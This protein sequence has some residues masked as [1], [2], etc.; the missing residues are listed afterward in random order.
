M[1]EKLLK[2]A[3]ALCGCLMLLCLCGSKARAADY[4]ISTNDSWV[5][6]SVADREANFYTFTLPSAGMVSVTLQSYTDNTNCDLLDEDLA[7]RYT[8]TTADGSSTNPDTERF[9]CDL[10]AGTYKI[11]LKNY[12]SWKDE[13]RYRLKVSFTPAQN[14]ETEPNNTFET[15]MPL[16]NGTLIKGFLSMDDGIDFYKITIGEGANVRT[17][18]SRGD[19]S[20]YDFSI[21]NSDL[22][23]VD[24]YSTSEQTRVWEKYLSPGTYYIKINESWGTGT[25]TLK[26]EGFRYVQSVKLKKSSLTLEKGKSYSLLKSIAPAGANNKNLRWTSDN[27]SVASV[28]SKGKVTAKGIGAATITAAA[29]DGSDVQA[30]CRII[31]KPNKTQIVTCKKVKDRTVYVKV[32]KQKNV[33]GIQY[34]LCR[35]KNFKGRKSS[36][37]TGTSGTSATT[38]ALS[39]NKTYYFRARMYIDYGG[40][41]YYGDWSTVKKIKT[42][43]RSYKKG[44]SSWKNV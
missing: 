2:W 4:S 21:W 18:V 39:K 24:S 25:Y 33:S 30:A 28:N 12:H 26:W 17:T 22:I 15:A 44:Y 8:G 10:E 7:K 43:K 11:R 3:A 5:D 31:V 23:E 27:T 41:R 37:Y 6:G 42:G 14:N 32:K 1:R 16:A 38:A 34:Q 19:I 40:K 9:S 13:I 36:Y 29:M 20:E 35:D